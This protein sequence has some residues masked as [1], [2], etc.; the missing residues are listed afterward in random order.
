MGAI[1]PYMTK[2]GKRY[3]A[4]YRRPDNSQTDKRGFK[5]KRDA[6]L[7]LASV[8]VAKARGEFVDA[9]ASRITVGELGA[10]W[11]ASRT[12]LKPSAL[13]PLEIAWRLFVEP[14]WGAR[15]LAS[16]NH[17]DVQTWVSQMSTGHAKTAH[18]SPPGPRSATVVRRAHGV[19]ASILDI[20]VKDRRIST[21]PARDIALPRK[22]KKARAYLTHEQVDIFA[23]A[24]GQHATFVRFLAYTG[25]RWGEAVGM[26]IRN[27]DTLRRRVTVR[28]NATRV[29]GKIIVGTPK[30]HEERSVPY[31]AFLSEPIARLC[32]GK[33][34]DM[35]LFGDGTNHMR[36]P[37]TRDGWFVVATRRAQAI[38]GT[39]PTLTPHDL[40]HTAAS[41]AIS[42]G[43]N[44]KAVQR[45]LGHSSAAMTLDIYADLFDDDLE[46]VATALDDARQLSIV[47]KPWAGTAATG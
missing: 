37:T 40:R 15:A 3:R 17:S 16:I 22:G 38:D 36:T 45:M 42:A 11:L 19:L 20:A 44:V 7:F 46:A 14:Q 1:D 43:A 30:T 29:G 2:A 34:P 18:Q 6:E 24:A 4:R 12:H 25:L 23:A 9:S 8:E 26:R 28:E 21:N 41:L 47:G 10:P 39:L 5:T 27:I 35:L 31:P 33:T 13:E 32:E